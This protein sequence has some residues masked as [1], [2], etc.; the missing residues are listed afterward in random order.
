MTGQRPLSGVRI[1]DLTNVIMGP[2]ATHILADMGADVIKIE[3]P[4]GDSLRAYK[5]SRSDN[6]SGV[7]LHLNRNKKSVVLDLKSED[8]CLALDRLIASADVFV[9]ALRPKAISR[10]GYPPARVRELNPDIIYCGA[11]G[12]STDGPYADKAAYDDIIQAGSGIAAMAARVGDT[13]EPAYVPTVLCDKLGGQ[14]IAYSIL[15]ALFARE[16]GAGGQ[17]IE[18][19]MFETSIEF[20][21]LEHLGGFAFEPSLGR[22]GFSRVLSKFRKPFKT[23][24]GYCCILPYSDRNWES[25]YDF[26]GRSELAKDPRYSRLGVRVQNID[27]LYSLIEREAPKYTNDQWV[28]FCD[29]HSVPCMPVLSIEDLPQD[30]HVQAVGMFT[31]GEHP[32]EGAYKVIRSPIRFSGSQFTVARHAP[33]LGQDTEEIL[34]EIEALEFRKSKTIRKESV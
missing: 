30:P 14:A 18:V 11:Y 9:H 6:M 28:S 2:F 25:F 32:T 31:T 27:D 26:V 21:L 16:R 13:G 22:P 19:P 8:G 23:A 17:D 34:A 4:D 15:A 7:F 12:F 3:S 5:P 10:L 1:I 24:D 33:A 20:M 29:E